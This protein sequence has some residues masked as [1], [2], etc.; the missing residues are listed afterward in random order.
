MKK[1]T[2]IIITINILF[3]CD[4]KNMKKKNRLSNSHS[5]Y[6]LQHATNPVDWYPWSF[7]AFER[8][9]KEN[10]PIFLSIGYATCHWCHVMEHES[11][12]DSSVA[13]IMNEKFINIKVDREE[14]PEIDHL[15]MSVCQA[16]TGRGGWPLTIIM[17]PEKEPFFA[18]T[19]FPK[20]SQGKRPGMLQLLP[21]LASAW[22]AKQDEIQKSIDKV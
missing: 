17:T 7:E 4:G 10:K 2:I 20:E 16:M 1:L 12:E 6:L 21:S 19:Y 3:N 5:P 9:K 13:Q 18:G 11:F 14:M 15:Y 22:V 8:A